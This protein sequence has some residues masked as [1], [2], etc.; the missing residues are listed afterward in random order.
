MCL[1]RNIFKAAKHYFIHC[2]LGGGSKEGW[3][4]GSFVNLVIFDVEIQAK[5]Q[6]KM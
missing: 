1:Y 4:C 3:W 2:V 6:E 5:M